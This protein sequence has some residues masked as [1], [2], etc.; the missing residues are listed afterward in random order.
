[1]PYAKISMANL[2]PCR[3][4][5][6]L[7]SIQR[8]WMPFTTT[9]EKLRSYRFLYRQITSGSSP[10][11]AITEKHQVDTILQ[12]AAIRSVSRIPHRSLLIPAAWMASLA[13]ATPWDIRLSPPVTS[14][15]FEMV[16][17]IVER[18]RAAS[19]PVIILKCT[20]I[21]DSFRRS[22]IRGLFA[23]LPGLLP[24]TIK[25]VL[26]LGDGGGTL[27]DLTYHFS[28]RVAY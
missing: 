23:F 5:I 7:F 18:I 3:T 21:R 15:R 26:W 22:L 2:S 25:E 12:K 19:M 11:L 8:P 4:D 28:Q 27:K 10:F 24:N 14:W 1:M 13:M 20:F 16:L 6:G 17:V 9:I